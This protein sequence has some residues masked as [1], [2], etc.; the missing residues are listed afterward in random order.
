[1]WIGFNMRSRIYFPDVEV[2]EPWI[3]FEGE[4][5][6]DFNSKNNSA[7]I[8]IDFTYK[9]KPENGTVFVVVYDKVSGLLKARKYVNESKYPNNHYSFVLEGLDA[10]GKDNYAMRIQME[11]GLSEILAKSPSID[12]NFT[13]DSRDL[14]ASGVEG[15]GSDVDSPV[16]YNLQGIRIDN[17][18]K[19]EIYIKVKGDKA[20]KVIF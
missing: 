7:E 10:D 9:N 18:V 2:T 1:M 17:P 12:L 3:G 8:Q 13:A 15:I 20:I 19:G 14:R 11:G 16:Y 5:T 4:P 6:V